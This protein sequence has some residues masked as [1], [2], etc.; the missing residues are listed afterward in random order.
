MVSEINQIAAIAK[1]GESESLRCP[2]FSGEAYLCRRSYH[3]RSLL[4]QGIH[5]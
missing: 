2:A 5:F 4:E 1:T 3:T